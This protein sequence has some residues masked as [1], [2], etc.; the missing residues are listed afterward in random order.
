MSAWK[1]MEM[2][3]CSGVFVALEIE[4]I[5]CGNL[6]EYLEGHG[7]ENTANNCWIPLFLN[8][9][10]WLAPKGWLEYNPVCK[11]PLFLNRLCLL[12][13]KG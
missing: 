4:P 6:H 5:L 13:P 3:L 11:I 12:A 10:C 1:I 8:G 2:S 7:D 9:L